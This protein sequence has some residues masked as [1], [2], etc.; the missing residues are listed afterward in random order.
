MAHMNEGDATL[1][2][3][4][5]ELGQMP[6]LMPEEEVCKKL[7]ESSYIKNRADDY[8][9]HPKHPSLLRAALFPLRIDKVTNDDIVGRLDECERTGLLQSFLSGENHASKSYVL[10]SGLGARANT[11]ELRILKCPAHA[12]QMTVKCAR[13]RMRVPNAKANIENEYRMRTMANPHRDV[14]R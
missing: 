1:N 6:L 14:K 7:R 4:M 3:Y 10:S 11:P 5:Q 9:R 8:G 13:I 12:R 2:R